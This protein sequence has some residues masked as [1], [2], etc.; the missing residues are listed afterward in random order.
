MEATIAAA[1]YRDDSGDLFIK[2]GFQF[3]VYGRKGDDTIVLTND[4]APFAPII[5][6]RTWLRDDV[7]TISSAPA[8]V[9]MKEVGGGALLATDDDWSPEQVVD[10]LEKRWRTTTSQPSPEARN[11]SRNLVWR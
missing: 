11:R 7:G 5:G 6:Q 9:R 3:I 10:A 2:K 8:G 1:A 4:R